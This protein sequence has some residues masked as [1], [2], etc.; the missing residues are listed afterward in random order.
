MKHNIAFILKAISLRWHLRNPQRLII[1]CMAL[2]IGCLLGNIIIDLNARTS[3][4]FSNA[5]SASTSSNGTTV[6]FLSPI[7]ATILDELFNYKELDNFHF[8]PFLESNFQF[9]NKRFPLLITFCNSNDCSKSLTIPESWKIYFTGVDSIRLYDT[10]F[11]IQA[12]DKTLATAQLD[13]SSIPIGKIE[14]DGL[15][16]FDPI[17]QVQSN[18]LKNLFPGIKISSKNEE[19]SDSDSIT[20]AFR[21]NLFALALVAL[22]VAGYLV[23][24]SLDISFENRSQLFSSMISLGFSKKDIG[25][26]ILVESFIMGLSMGVLAWLFGSILAEYG[27]KFFSLFLP[28][29]FGIIPTQY[30]S[31]LPGTI[32]IP[33]GILVSISSAFLAYRRREF[34]IG[35]K[36]ESLLKSKQNNLI[37][38]LLFLS[39]VFFTF[40]LFYLKNTAFGYIS[41]TLLF[42]LLGNL[43]YYSL[44]LVTYLYPNGIQWKLAARALNG[45]N[46]RFIAPVS[47][48]SV[49][50]SLCIAMTVLISSFRHTLTK[51]LE[52]NIRADIY[53]SFQES[54]SSDEKLSYFN[55][56]NS[57]YPGKVLSLYL[58]SGTINNSILSADADFMGQSFS[59]IE[60]I[61][62]PDIIS[63]SLNGVLASET[64]SMRWNLKPGDRINLPDYN[65]SKQIGGIFRNYTGRKGTFL[66]NTDD[67]SISPLFKNMNL[68]G[69]AIY[70]KE[71]I[72]LDEFMIQYSGIG[73]FQRSFEIRSAALELFDKTFAITYILQI[74][75]F[76][77]ASAAIAF[78]LI[79]LLSARKRQFAILASLISNSRHKLTV[80]VIYEALGVL[81]AAILLSIPSSL[82]LTWI[83]IDGINR[84]SFGWTLSWEI[85]YLVLGLILAG[86]FA[87]GIITALIIGVRLPIRRVWHLIKSRE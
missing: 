69:F 72:S 83:L 74:I 45:Y 20:S 15:F 57:D 28:D 29:V 81:L 27:W 47:A 73:T 58:G 1:A 48:L 8:I 26:A 59:K 64:A 80:I 68:A 71:K 85:P 11:S 33:L 34:Q 52:S 13:I 2:F 75:T 86:S 21:Q 9:N 60:S 65:I 38:F 18:I 3:S 46:Q 43:S 70:S 62:P 23:Y 25:I 79:S 36:R 67:E 40:L 50:I 12:G 78:S 16:S 22:L 10:N 17:D 24:A 76:I 31:F 44:K 51:W 4:S 14:I 54:I 37:T 30:N 61:N 63:G 7:K 55:L 41:V 39:I 82:Y 32:I 87:S 42:I 84:Y 49:A 77:L 6:R 5:M 35:R 56:A 53:L 19:K 66:F